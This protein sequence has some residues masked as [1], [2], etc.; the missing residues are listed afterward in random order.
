[1]S[2][3]KRVHRFG[4]IAKITLR[5]VLPLFVLSILVSCGN[6]YEE[7]KAERA[8]AVNKSDTINI[9]VIWDKTVKE[10]LL[11]EGISQAADEINEKGG[12]FRRKIRIQVFYSENDADE[13][14]LAKK[15]ATDASFAAVIGHRSATNAIPAS[16]TYEYYGILF[17]SPS[18]S[19]NNLTNHGFEYTFRTIPSDYYVSKEIADFMKFQGHKQVA[20]LDDRSIYGKGIAD[21]VM[22]S[23]AEIGLTVTVRRHYSPGKTDFK[24]LCA[25]LSRHEFDVLFIGGMLPEAAELIREA[26]QMGIRQRVYGG[27]AIDSRA[28]ERIAG[29]A[30]N[31]TVVPTSF[32]ADLDNP[33]TQAFVNNFRKRYGK[34]PDTRA[35]L[36]YDS[37]KILIDAMKRSKSADPSVVASNMRFIKNWQ[38][39]TGSYTYNLKGDLE[40]KKSY[41]KRLNQTRFIYFDA[42]KEAKDEDKKKD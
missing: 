6:N 39:V 17:I 10:F 20:I 25:E 33:V 38:G 13:Q 35:A 15:V 5:V 37:L 14:R 26:R 21:G 8:K 24:P 16:I 7:V 4:F 41:F 23:L 36:G 30:S 1:M 9:A 12:L 31:G 40:G 18:S 11:V 19:S 3:T 29:S 32:F 2:I 34:P 22:E 27:D 28:L 42:P